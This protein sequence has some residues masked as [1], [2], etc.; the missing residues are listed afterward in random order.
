MDE[1]SYAIP[2]YAVPF[3][4]LQMNRKEGIEI[5]VFTRVLKSFSEKF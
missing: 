1:P 4:G 3:P 2:A 5:E